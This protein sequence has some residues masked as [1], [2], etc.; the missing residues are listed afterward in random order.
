LQFHG[1]TASIAGFTTKADNY[2]SNVEIDPRRTS[3]SSRTRQKHLAKYAGC[4]LSG[5]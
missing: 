1:H 3:D 2:A 5:V 4:R